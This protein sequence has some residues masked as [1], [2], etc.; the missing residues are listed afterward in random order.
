M[1]LLNPTLA[2]LIPERPEVDEKHPQHICLDKAYDAQQCRQDLRERK[3]TPHIRSR[4]EEKQQKLAL[5]QQSKPSWLGR[6]TQ[7]VLTLLG[8]KATGEEQKPRRW[9][10]ERTHSW[11][12]R[13]RKIL[14]RFEKTLESH[15]G[16][17][18]LACAHIVLKRAGNC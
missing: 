16:L 15:W 17:L 14:V 2:T 4:G 10:V 18:Q 11:L 7:G 8:M 6:L 1:P 12:N 13:F 3:Y 5:S 9:V